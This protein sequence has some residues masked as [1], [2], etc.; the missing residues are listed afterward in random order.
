MVLPWE[1]PTFKVGQY[2]DESSYVV[3]D[4]YQ[5][6]IEFRINSYRDLWTLT[7]LKDVYDNAGMPLS[8]TIPCL[9]DAQADKRFNKN[10]SS[11]LKLVLNHLKSLNFRSIRIF[12]PHNQEV[13]EAVLDNVEFIDNSFFIEN[14]IKDIKEKDDSNLVLM[15]SDAGGFK[16]LVKLC[17]KINWEGEMYSASKSRDPKTHKLT[18]QLG[19]QNFEG[20]NVLIVDDICVKGGTFIGLAEMLRQRNVW[21]IYLAVSHMTIP[22]PNPELV[23]L[24]EKVYTTNSKGIGYN[25]GPLNILKYE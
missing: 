24:F 22:N 23:N 13:I 25:V 7:Q 18:Q 9:L 6:H 19:K 21:G 15:S 4:S 2:P 1:K 20:K 14:V 8:I 12:H 3:V 11:G 17:D 10:E 16:P 5:P